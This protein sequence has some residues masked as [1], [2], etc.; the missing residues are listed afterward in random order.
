MQL[1]KIIAMA[2]ESTKHSPQTA[3][4]AI[5]IVETKD[6]KQLLQ[7]LKDYTDQVFVQSLLDLSSSHPL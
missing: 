2:P 3:C 7:K 5:F 1:M 6:P 4:T